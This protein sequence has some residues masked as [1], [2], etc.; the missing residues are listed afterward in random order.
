MT[1]YLSLRAALTATCIAMALAGH[2]QAFTGLELGHAASATG[3]VTRESRPKIGQELTVSTNLDQAQRLW[4]GATILNGGVAFPISGN[5]LDRIVDVYRVAGLTTRY[6]LGKRRFVVSPGVTVGLIFDAKTRLVFSN[7]DVERSS[8]DFSENNRRFLFIPRLDLGY[9]ASL[10][11]MPVQFGVTSYITATG[12]RAV[13]T[14][15]PPQL[16][17]VGLYV[18]ARLNRTDK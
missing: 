11:T 14:T 18:R 16:W 17:G 8:Q 9:R 15:S 3:T 4:L 5:V 12:F 7:G 1:L 6:E 2:A 13:Q 10:G